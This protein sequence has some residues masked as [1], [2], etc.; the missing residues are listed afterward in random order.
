MAVFNP[1]MQ[2]VAVWL[3]TPEVTLNGIRQETEISS[4]I[5]FSRNTNN[6]RHKI[7]YVW[8]CVNAE[9][10]HR[11][12]H[13]S[14]SSRSSHRAIVLTRCWHF[15]VSSSNP[16]GS[17]CRHDKELMSFSVHTTPLTTAASSGT[18][19]T[20]RSANNALVAS[21]NIILHHTTEE[22]PGELWASH[23]SFCLSAVKIIL[24]IAPSRI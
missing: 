1:A 20:E 12:P 4:I 10:L 6:A 7:N 8:D 19:Q 2:F 13:I 11:I 3:Y 21:S 15:T 18:Q 5:S 17:K 24:H 9:L 14:S 16:I 23:S 22:A